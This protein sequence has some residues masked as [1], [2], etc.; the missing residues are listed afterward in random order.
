MSK[1][2]RYKF[3]HFEPNAGKFD[4]VNTKTGDI[5]GFIDWYDPWRCWCLH[6][7]EGVAFSASCLRSICDFIKQRPTKK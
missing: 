5:L 3:I 1:T 6:T 4:I 2:V 7:F